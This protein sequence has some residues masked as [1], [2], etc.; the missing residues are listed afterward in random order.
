MREIDRQY[1][2]TPFYGS[3]RIVA[4]LKTQGYQVNRKRVQRLPCVRWALRPYTGVHGL[5]NQ[6][7]DTR[8]ITTCYVE[9]RLTG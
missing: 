5:A 3:R 6:C 1:M 8:S 7:R 4:W 9:W 2:L